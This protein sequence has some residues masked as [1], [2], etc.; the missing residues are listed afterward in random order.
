[1]R[2]CVILNHDAFGLN[3]KWYPKIP[4]HYIGLPHPHVSLVITSES[5][6]LLFSTEGRM[7]TSPSTG[8]SW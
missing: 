6:Q 5:A 8:I 7:H 1:M 2:I 3:R 4:S